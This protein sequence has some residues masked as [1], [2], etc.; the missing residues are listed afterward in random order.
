M[1]RAVLITCFVLVTVAAIQGQASATKGSTASSQV[2]LAKTAGPVGLGRI[3]AVSALLF[4]FTNAEIPGGIV[5]IVNCYGSEPQVK[6][7]ADASVKQLLEIVALK[8]PEYRWRIDDGVVNVIPYTSF[9]VP[10]DIRISEFQVE[11]LSALDALNRLLDN[12]Q[13]KQELQARGLFQGLKLSGGGFPISKKR[14]TLDLKDSTLLEALNAIVRSDGRAVW[15][16]TL[17]PCNGRNEYEINLL[18]H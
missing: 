8:V 18:V 12:M 3:D 16:Y 15:G 10:L 4:G 2:V 5:R 6:I 14:I 13:L 11:E 9:P 17:R 7:P 1:L